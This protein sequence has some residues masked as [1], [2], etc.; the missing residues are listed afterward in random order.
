MRARNGIAFLL[1]T[2]GAAWVAPELRAQTPAEMAQTAAFAAS[3][4]NE[5]GGFSD[6]AVGQPSTLGATNAAIRI[7]H[8]VGGSVPDV[9]GCV[10]F[11]RSCRVPGGGFSS[12]PGGKPD[13]IT[14]AVGLLAASELK[15][16][17]PDMI[18]ESV[19]YLG[20][21]A[22]AFEEVRMAAAGLE[23]IGVT[24]PDAPRWDHQIQAMR[25]PGGTFGTGAGIPFATGGSAAAILRL[26]MPLE[27]RQAIVKAI[28]AGQTPEGGFSRDGGPPDL[29]S[30]YRIVRALY[31]MRE[32]PNLDNLLGFVARCRKSDGSYSVTPDGKGSLGGTYLGTILTYWSRQLM[33]LPAV[34]ETAG[35]R[36]MVA[37]DSLDGWEGD[38]QLWSAKDGAIIGRS[39][40]LDH[41]EFLATTR[42][43]GDFILSM[44]F[45][46]EHGQG[47]SGIQFRSVRVP[48]HEMSGYQA[49]IGEGFWG[50]LYDESRRNMVLVYPRSE[51]VR[52]LRRSG[53]N[54]YVIRAMG[55][56]ITLT[57]N[58][59]DSVRQYREPDPRI[60]REGLVAVQ[61]HAGGSMEVQFRDILIQPL[62]RPVATEPTQPGFRI[63]T[64]R[65]DHGERRYTVY[66]PEGYDGTKQL[67]V[68]LFLHGSGERGSDGV[69][70]AQVGLGPAILG[71]QGGIPAVVVFP[72]ARQSWAA[73][74]ADGAA[75]LKALDE[76]MREYKCDPKRVILTGLSMGGRGSWDIATRHPERFAAV[77]PICGPGDVESTSSL[78]NIPVWTFCGD[79]DREETVL[80]LRTMVDTLQRLGSP[81]RL[82]EYRGVGHNS[83]DRAY[84]SPGLI[85]W[86]LTQRKL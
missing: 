1:L 19:A 40:G 28:L 77:V 76:V 80:N 46:L 65:T 6:Q 36:P 9:L 67:P 27:N 4:Q 11:V 58:G 62:P 30:S 12:R 23:A 52:G 70:P 47:N 63:R 64:L 56:R 16:D 38:R 24:S 42:P 10:K 22:R 3:H 54:H 29:S 31:M 17:D 60:A 21:H 82:T 55:D 18:R 72:Q 25:N 26:G 20:R 35:F 44:N 43:Y 45:R 51:A 85:E 74:S 7:L 49:D 61:M 37:G 78:R 79:A 33:G 41:N 83:W 81:A 34:V 53:W 5:D 86:M 57:L 15:I 69:T 14:T 2:A 84:N 48:G 32:R 75:A 71:R 73:D 50:A 39:S 66:V 59:Q 13:P 8:Y 68:V